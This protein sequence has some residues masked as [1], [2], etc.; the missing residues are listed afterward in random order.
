MKYEID[1]RYI[2]I[3]TL[4]VIVCYILGIL[5]ALSL[6]KLRDPM[7]FVGSSLFAGIVVYFMY[8][9]PRKINMKDGI[10]SFVEN[11][12]RDRTE[13]KLIDIVQIEYGCKFYNTVT[14]L[15]KSGTQYELHPKDAKALIDD[16]HSHK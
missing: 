5:I 4:L 14:I 2:A 9:L 15:T 10:I 6:L 13:V 3:R 8:F 1:R 12:R 16:I 7:G 11:N